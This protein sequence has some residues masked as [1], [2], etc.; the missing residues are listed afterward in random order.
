MLRA[1]G[2]EGVGL[3]DQ[4]LTAVKEMDEQQRAAAAEVI[5]PSLGLAV[6]A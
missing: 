5:D 4:L 1:L 3:A 6:T 2:G